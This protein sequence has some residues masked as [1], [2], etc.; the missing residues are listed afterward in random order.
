MFNETSNGFVSST[1]LGKLLRDGVERVCGF[2]SPEMPSC[3]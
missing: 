2:P 3:A 1:L